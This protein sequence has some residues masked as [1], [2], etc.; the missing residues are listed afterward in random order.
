METLRELHW[1]LVLGLGALALVRPLV[2][3]VGGQAGIDEPP[4]VA[5]AV[6]LAISLVWI[7]VVGLTRV[8]H[9]LLTLVM[10]GLTY[11]V[12]SMLL[13]A[14]LSPLLTGRAQGPLATPVAI[15]PVLLTNAVWGAAAGLLALVLRRLRSG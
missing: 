12:L 15:V 2:R 5:V 8:A 9:P 10:V 13:A 6:T 7:A 4:A 1:P 14:V 11:A 3:I